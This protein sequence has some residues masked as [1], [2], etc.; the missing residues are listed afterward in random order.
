MP[1]MATQPV[2]VPICLEPADGKGVAKVMDA[3]TGKR[4]VFGFTACRHPAH[5][6]SVVRG[7][8]AI[9]LSIPIRKKVAVTGSLPQQGRCIPAW[10]D[11]RDGTWPTRLGAK[12]SDL[13]A[14]MV[15][16]VSHQT[17]G[18]VLPHARLFQQVENRGHSR[19][20]GCFDPRYRIGTGRCDRVAP[21]ADDRAVK[22]QGRVTGN[23]APC[24]AGRQQAGQRGQVTA[25]RGAN[26]YP[27]GNTG[28][29]GVMTTGL[30]LKIPSPIW[31]Q[32]GQMDFYVNTPTPVT[33]TSLSFDVEEGN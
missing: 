4:D 6:L 13:L 11:P 27:I 8:I 31:T 28:S 3:K 14:F 22:G 19:R 30:A 15:H 1:Q 17:D 21:F 29:A 25:N 16:I 18:F 10:R 9:G 32:V 26:T 24:H 23:P 20:A 5:D 7:R 33:L 2:D 12:Q